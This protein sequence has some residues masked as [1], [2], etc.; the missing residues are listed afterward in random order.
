[1]ISMILNYKT[2]LPVIF[3]LVLGIVFIYAAIDKISDPYTFAVDIRNYRILPDIFSNFFALILPWIE[4]FCGLFLIIGIFIR[5]SAII[6]AAMLMVFI[7]A[8]SLA[9]IRGLNIDCG[10][11]HT[12]GES[13]K[14]GYNKLIEDF[15][16][17]IM[18]GYLFLTVNI[19]PAIQ[20]KKRSNSIKRI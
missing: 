8:I 18:A 9:M 16:Y 11:Y 12:M 3:R 7:L 19:G 1:M 15:I 2:V 4:L 5:S 17:L 13:T 6:I 20:I 14:I 10:C